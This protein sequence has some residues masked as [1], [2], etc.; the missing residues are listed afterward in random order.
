[1]NITVF[2]C[3]Y[4]GLT[5]AVGL[6]EMG[7]IV[8]GI[9]T[10]SKKITKLSK[11]LVPFYEP[12]LAELLQRNIKEKRLIFS[13]DARRGVEESEVIFSAV[14]TPPRKDHHADLTAVLEVAKAFG[15]Y[16]A[17]GKVFVNKSTV[18]VGTSEEIRKTIERA[19]KG[20]KRFRNAKA[21][22]DFDVISN[23]EF[24][25]EGSAVQDFFSPDR[26]VVGLE[27]ESP[28]LKKLVRIIYRPMADAG[29]PIYFTDIRSAEVIK[30][31][32]N[33]YLATRISLIN[34]LANFCEKAGADIKKVAEG[35]GL[36]KRIGTHYLE[37]GIGYGGSCLP[38]D[39]TALIEIG[40]KKGFNFELLKAVRSVNQRQGN[41]ITDKLKRI[42][43]KLKGKK[44]AVWGVAF[45]PETDDIREAPSIGII[46]S[47][48]KAGAKVNIYDPAAL[49]NARAI[50]GNKINYYS[51]YYSAL[52]HTDALIILTE[53]DELRS[54]DYSKMQSMMKGNYILDCRNIL[55]PAEAKKA[56][57]EYR[58]IGRG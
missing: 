51:N 26:I 43:G 4:V 27:K 45:K 38:K 15:K 49:E 40:R 21:G 57:F 18:P 32:S 10:D 37:A 31:A 33:V 44:I 19:S 30:Y 56:G 25:R 13:A 14:G 34:E 2:G 3:G 11:G 7:Y 23:P 22:F 42:L 8:L 1:M 47:L 28:R 48:L 55:D 5:T 6:A 54:P 58:G 20:V 17:K 36:D 50:F 46:S 52:S 16:G 39:L 41:A 53:W 24:L 29:I 35:M 12:G 9:D